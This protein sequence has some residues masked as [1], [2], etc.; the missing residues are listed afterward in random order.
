ML[1]R[2]FFLSHTYEPVDIPTQKE[3]DAYLPSPKQRPVLDPTD[4]R[5]FYALVQPDSYME[6][7]YHVQQAHLRAVDVVDAAGKEWGEA[8]GRP[9]AGVE[10][11]D[12]DDAET[13]LVTSSSTT[14]PAR[15][16][17]KKLRAE[18]VPIGLLK[19]RLFRPFPVEAVLRAL[20]GK[21]KAIV[22]DRNISFGKG[23]IFSD[24]LRAAVCNDPRRPT[25]FGYITGL[26]GRDITP[27]LLESIVRD[28]ME[29]DA[30]EG[31]AVFRGL[32]S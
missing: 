23:G 25:V 32:L 5:A 30:P 19:I 22:V 16:V 7:R 9:Y 10:A 14:S 28:A 21:R 2:V 13:V 27:D 3:I 12:C 15:L 8:F 1:R 20:S 4:P 26:G 17:Q 18:G 29:A 11:V 24:E 6:M 31:D